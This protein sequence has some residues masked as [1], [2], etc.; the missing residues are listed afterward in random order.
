MNV[1]AITIQRD[2]GV[3]VINIEDQEE[4]PPPCSLI[5][6]ASGPSEMLVTQSYASMDEYYAA[7]AIAAMLRMLRESSLSQY[8]INV[9]TVRGSS[10]V[11][12]VFTVRGSSVVISVFTVR[13]SSVVISV[14]TVRGSS[15]VISVFTVRGSSVVIS[16]FTVRGS[17]VVISVFTVRALQ[18][19]SVYSL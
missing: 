10:V 9:F 17:S 16:V 18:L 4:A 15:V 3:A 2:T 14:F 19:L 7:C 13:G 1:G 11:I 6:E 8:H 12:S 5:L